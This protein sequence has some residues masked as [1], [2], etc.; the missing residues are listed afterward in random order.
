MYGRAAGSVASFNYP[1]ALKNAH[2]MWDANSLDKWLAGSDK[3]VP[4][5]DMRD[6]RVFKADAVSYARP[7]RASSP[8]L[9]GIDKD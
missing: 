7:M 2:I 9:A 3:V 6:H 5:T 4:E 8:T 1:D